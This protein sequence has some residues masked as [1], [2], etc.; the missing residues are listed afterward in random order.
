MQHFTR[1]RT[2]AAGASTLLLPSVAR[3]DAGWPTG[4]V[5]MVVGYAAGGGADINARELAQILSPLIGQQAIV[6]NKGGAA[7]S[8]GVRVVASAKPD[9]QTL[10]YAVGTNVIINPHIQK[11][12]IDTITALA[13]I[14]QT[15]AYQ[16]VLAINPKVPA[17]SA[18]ELVTL[19]RKEPEKLTFSSSGVG[20]N[21]HL[22]GALFAE[23]AGIKLTHVPYKGT[24]PALA[25][26]ISGQITMNFSS[27]PPAVS[28]IKAGNLRALAVTGEKRVKSLPEVPTLKEQG[29]DVVVTSWHGLFAPARTA[30]AVLDKIEKAAKEAMAD[31]K[32]EAA[33]SKDGLELAPARSRPEFT[34]FV[35]E[36]HDYWGKK[37]KALKIEM[38]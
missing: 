24:G 37:L 17:N 32:W 35:R 4:P 26:V 13:P 31:P 18:A 33:L 11:G 14:C 16:Y 2:L 1:R 7:G 38:E 20:G 3:A 12:M 27:L 8:L 6:D 9:G 36:E 10:F 25:D 21:N 28:Q 23:A 34:A 22:A 30:D 19:A 5:T 15:T 29:I